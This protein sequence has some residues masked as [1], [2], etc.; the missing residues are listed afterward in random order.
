M[1]PHLPHSLSL[2]LWTSTRLVEL[3]KQRF[4][5]AGSELLFEFKSSDHLGSTLVCLLRLPEGCVESIIYARVSMFHHS[6]SPLSAYIFGWN[7]VLWITRRIWDWRLTSIPNRCVELILDVQDL[8]LRHLWDLE[9]FFHGSHL[10][11]TLRR[12]YG[13]TEEFRNRYACR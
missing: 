6:W 1:K 3:E 8:Q 12:C 2:S 7:A 10:L 4:P 5:L 9:F 13:F 11:S